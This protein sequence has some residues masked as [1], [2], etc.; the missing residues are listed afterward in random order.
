MC[1]NL[2]KNQ[3]K[4]SNK[5]ILH[6]LL[7]RLPIDLNKPGTTTYGY[8]TKS[9]PPLGLLYIAGSLENA[10]HIVE[11]ID[12]DFENPSIYDLK[13]KFIN[14]NNYWRTSLYLF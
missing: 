11:I 3:N 7:F 12:L 8:E 4:K 6:F 1:N 13:N 5:K 9:Y 14:S 2:E 10:G